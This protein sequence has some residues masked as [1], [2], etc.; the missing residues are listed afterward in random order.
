MKIYPLLLLFVLSSCAI[1]PSTRRP[2]LKEVSNASVRQDFCSQMFVQEAC[3]LVHS[4]SFSMVN[5][6]GNTLLGIIVIDGEKIKTTLMGVEGFV[7]FAADLGEDRE[8]TVHKSLPPFDNPEFAKGLMRD[9]RTLFVVPEYVDLL[10][11]ENENNETVCRYVLEE[12]RVLDVIATG[13][14][15]SRVTIYDKEG[16][17][18]RLVT[19]KR[20]K[21]VEGMSLAESIELVSFGVGAYTLQLNL[22]RAEKSQL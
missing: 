17:R 18:E 13:K 2:E 9:V 16:K 7:L 21:D 12:G 22:L 20:Y 1:A 5:G 8:I 19:A 10:L 14:G 3:Q 6:Y 15:Y 4:I 11:G